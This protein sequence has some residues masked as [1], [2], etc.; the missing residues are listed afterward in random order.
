[1]PSNHSANPEFTFLEDKH[2]ERVRKWERVRREVS[3]PLEMCTQLHAERWSGAPSNGFDF[4][5]LMIRKWCE[6]WRRDTRRGR[7]G[8]RRKSWVESNWLIFHSKNGA[9]L[10]PF[11]IQHR[12]HDLFPSLC[13]LRAKKSIWFDWLIFFSRTRVYGHYVTQKLCWIIKN[14]PKSI[15]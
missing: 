2:L 1:M 5:Y 15:L 7:R 4:H 3:R 12:D 6:G 14:L 11:S 9:F 8:F 10:H 13:G